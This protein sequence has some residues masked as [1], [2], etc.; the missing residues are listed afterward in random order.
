MKQ[1][2]PAALVLV[3]LVGTGAL[4]EEDL[5]AEQ[6]LYCEMVQLFESSKGEYGWPDY[7]RRGKDCGYQKD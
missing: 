4:T 7:E 5:Q 3:A 2:L 6:Q 1:F